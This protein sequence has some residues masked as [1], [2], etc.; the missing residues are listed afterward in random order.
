MEASE[1]KAHRIHSS[2][3]KL[4]TA[5]RV[6]GSGNCN[7]GKIELV[8]ALHDVGLVFSS[9]RPPSDR[10]AGHQPAPMQV[11]PAGVP[12]DTALLGR[13]VAT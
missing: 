7:G 8:A 5:V 3:C 2:S 12:I 6:P 11:E 13:V 10:L 1:E 9:P 4:P